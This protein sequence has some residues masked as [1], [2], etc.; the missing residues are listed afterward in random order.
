VSVQAASTCVAAWS[1]GE[2]CSILLVGWG[3]RPR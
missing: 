1:V 2:N 3:G